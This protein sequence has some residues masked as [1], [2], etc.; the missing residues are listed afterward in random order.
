MSESAKNYSSRC[1]DS[2]IHN[3]PR[4]AQKILLRHIPYEYSYMMNN[5]K[6]IITILQ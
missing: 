1:K 4:V 6:G 3:L 5:M 2:N